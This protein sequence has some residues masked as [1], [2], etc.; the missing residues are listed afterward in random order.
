M[1]IPFGE[2]KLKFQDV[3]IGS[4]HLFMNTTSPSL[5]DQLRQPAATGAWE[6]FV[7][8]YSGLL[9]SWARR[10]GLGE[11]DAADL[12]QDVFLNLLRTLPRFEYDRT[13]GFRR[14]LRTVLINKWRDRIRRAREQAADPALLAAVPDPQD[15]DALAEAEYR[16]HLVHAALRL[17][18]AEFSENTWRACWEHVV[19]G[20]PA[21][22]VA[23]EL[24]IEKGSVYVAKARVLQRLRQELAGLWE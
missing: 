23:Q 24:G 10:L 19:Q 6:R 14:W 1:A 11:N 4:R 22:E 21:A 16:Q 5:L 7:R 15:E 8:L 9:F 12:L 17:M 2:K 13:R 20:R 3:K 18:R